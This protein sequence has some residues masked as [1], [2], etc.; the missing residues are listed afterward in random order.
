MEGVV[1]F[2]CVSAEQVRSYVTGLGRRYAPLSLKLNA[3]AIRSF[4]AFAWMAGW[5]RRDLTGAVGT[6]V[7]HRSGRLP[8]SVSVAEVQRLVQVP[9]RRTCVGARDYAVLD[10]LCRLGLRAGEVAGVCLDDFDWRSATVSPKV[11]GGRRLTLPVPCDVGEAV[12]AYLQRRPAD[13]AWREV[14]LRVR[15]APV[16]LTSRAIT[17]VLSSAADR[18]SGARLRVMV[19]VGGVWG[20]DTSRI[21]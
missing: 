1:D 4:L 20:G 18:V 11:K 10:M 12:V 9:D 13:T 16:P 3:T 17:Q 15:G 5:T 7:T 19:L 14:F 8:K 21:S 6:V 2:T